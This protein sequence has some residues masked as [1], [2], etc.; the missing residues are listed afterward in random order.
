MPAPRSI[1]IT[2]D[3][4]DQLGSQPLWAWQANGL[5]I[6]A[7]LSDTLTLLEEATT[8]HA[9]IHTSAHPAGATPLAAAS[10]DSGEEATFDFTTAAMS[11]SIGATATSALR[12]LFITARNEAGDDLQT[13]YARAI[14][15]KA[16]GYSGADP[17]PP[18]VVL[19]A[20]VAT[21]AALEARIEELEDTPPGS[22]AWGSIAGTLG[23]QT[24]VSD[25]FLA[26][27]VARIAT[28]ADLQAQ[29]DLVA[30]TGTPVHPSVE[31]DDRIEGL[32]ANDSVLKVFSTQNHSTPSYVRSA[33]CWAADFDLTCASPWNSGNA[34]LWAGVAITPR[35]FVHAQHAFVANGSTIRFITA[36]NTVVTRSVVSGMQ[37]GSS[38]IRVSLLNSDLPDTITPAK[39]LPDD[40]SHWITTPD[41]G[42]NRTACGF[43]NQEEKIFVGDLVELAASLFSVWAPTDSQRL[44]FYSLPISGDSGN[45][46][47]LFPHG[48]T[49]LIGC[50]GTAVDGAS[51]IGDN[52]AGVL[53]AI[54]TLGAYGHTPVD[55]VLDP[56]VRAALENITGLGTMAAQDADD[57]DISG[58]SIETVEIRNSSLG[59]STIE[60]DVVFDDPL[61][62]RTA[63]DAQAASDDLTAIAAISDF[64]Y[65]YYRSGAGVWSPVTI[66]TNLSFSS[67]TLSATGEVGGSVAWGDI[68]GT[69]SNQTDLQTALDAKAPINNAVFT[70]TL[71]TPHLV[72]IGS[73]GYQIQGD[74]ESGIAVLPLGGGDLATTANITTAIAALGSLSTQS[75]TFSGGGTLATGG[76]TLTV[77]ATASIAG[78]HTGTSS[79]TNTGDQT[80]TLTG[81]VTGSG[82]GSFAATIANDAVTFAKM[83]NITTD[84][85]LG[86][87]TASTGDPEEITVGGGLE[88]TGS[89]GIQRSALT[90]DATASAGSNALTIA[91]DAV[92]NAK[93]ANMAASTVKARITGS[94]GDPEDATVAQVNALLQ[95]DGLTNDAAGFR[96]IPQN[97]RSAAYTIAAADNGKHILHPSADTTARTFTIDSNANL[98]LPIGFTVTFVNQASGGVITIAITTDTMRLAGAGTTG[99]RT[100]A[101]NGV[102]TAIKLTSTEWIIS[103]VG[104]T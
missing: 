63:L 8:F 56:A 74:T 22:A 24:D 82:T 52:R 57:V 15:I 90:G 47:F 68:T 99:S 54:E 102:A 61:A 46:I 96:G 1:D 91:N 53:A 92:S 80:I 2:L 23:D 88:F 95:A 83:Q 29:I 11:F 13:L 87:D 34:N 58:G 81:D 19:Y 33:T 3:G 79:G 76:F 51:L 4:R 7:A 28:D 104:L 25:A 89:G 101:A 32:T 67:G 49:V 103:G 18:A 26:E 69:L 70:G 41:N 6:N 17:D 44:D 73:D 10:A 39:L 43:L 78:T 100:L 93:L 66:G 12:Y 5:T 75:G 62:T 16:G 31:V 60:S 35:H 55:V 30:V 85:L 50:W 77:S 40:W 21:V 59:A 42:S 64:G 20:P 72:N 86:R 97:S 98:A 36:D 14:E 48:E 38:D 45:P 94:T 37:V 71:A 9:E 27:E 65:F 84:R